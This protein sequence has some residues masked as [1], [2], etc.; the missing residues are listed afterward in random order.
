MAKMTNS[1]GVFVWKP[2]KKKLHGRL[3]HRFLDDIKMDF[4][5]TVSDYIGHF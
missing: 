1:C 5:E 3:R 2:Q 4:K